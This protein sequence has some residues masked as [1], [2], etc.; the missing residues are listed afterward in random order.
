MPI[1]LVTSYVLYKR[2]RFLVLYMSMGMAV[3]AIDS[4]F[5]AET[6]GFG[7]HS[8]G[9][10]GRLRLGY[11]WGTPESNDQELGNTVMVEPRGL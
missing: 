11:E 10:R 9:T 8:E 5:G 4:G 2:C 3:D 7:K 1:A 6:E